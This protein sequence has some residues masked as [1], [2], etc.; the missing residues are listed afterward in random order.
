MQSC[1]EQIDMKQQSP[2]ELHMQLNKNSTNGNFTTWPAERQGTLSVD[3]IDNE[4]GKFQ[5]A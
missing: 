4:K 3:C 2:N 5:L 1:I